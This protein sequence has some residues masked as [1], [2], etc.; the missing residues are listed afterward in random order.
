M[1]S[2]VPPSSTS[3]FPSLRQPLRR[4]KVSVAHIPLPTRRA[5][6]YAAYLDD[7]FVRLMVINL[8]AY[9]STI[10]GIGMVPDPDAPDRPVFRY[11]FQVPLRRGEARVQRL[12]ANGSDAISG[13]SWDGWSYN[14]DLDG[15]RP[16]R[17]TNVTTG[18]KVAV[19]D[20]VVEVDV[21]ASQAVMLSFVELT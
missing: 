11:A 8:Q 5:A 2:P 4:P 3:E 19:T 16:V 6:A 14:L 12:Y 20:G 1:L 15:G 13:I 10:S 17:L 21:E 7:K 9:N 18:E